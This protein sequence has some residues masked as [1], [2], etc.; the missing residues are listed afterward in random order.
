MIGDSM[1]VSFSRSVR[2]LEAEHSQHSIVLL[3]TAITLIILWLMWFF[4]SSVTLS[5]TSLSAQLTDAARL[6]A[7]FPAAV[8]SQIR[9]GQTGQVQVDGFPAAQYGTLEFKVA[10]ISDELADGQVQATLVLQPSAS[11]SIPLRSGLNGTV[12]LDLERVSPATWAL[13]LAGQQPTSSASS[14]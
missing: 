2:S 10:D 7:R 9:L 13:R 11:N 1:S 8:L 12:E 6:T 4:F 5:V 3:L 14:N